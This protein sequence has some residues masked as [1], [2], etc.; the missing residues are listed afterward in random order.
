[1]TRPFARWADEP[2]PTLEPHV[3]AWLAEHLGQLTPAPAVDAAEMDVPESALAAPALAALRQAVGDA[4]VRTDRLA[5][6]RNAAGASYDDLLRLRSGTDLHIPDAVVAPADESEV[7]AVLRAASEHGVAVVPLGG[8]TSVVGGVEPIAGG[9]AAVVVLDLSRMS[10][11]VHLEADD[12]TARFL[13]GTT[14]PTADALLA[15]QGMVLGHVPQSYA[16]ASIGGYAATR[17]AGQSSTGFGRFDAMVVGVRMATPRGVLVAGTGTANAAGPDLKQVVVGSEGA[18]GVIT[19]VAVRV[20]RA[21]EVR[22][23]EGWVLPGFGAG[24]DVL[25]SL[26]QDGPRADSAPDVCRL[27]DPQETQVQLA[28]RG[29]GAQSAAL[30]AYLRLRKRS[31]GCLAIVGWEGRQAAVR[32]RRREAVAALRAS[33]GVSLGTAAGE[34]W[35]RNRFDAPSQRDSLIAA[36]VLVETLETATTWSRVPALRE[37]IR[38]ALGRSLGEFGTPPVVMTHLSHL[39]PTGASLYVTVLARQVEGD[40]AAAREQ[41]H[42]AKAAA[43]EAILA[44]GGTLTHHHAVGRDHRPWLGREVGDLG[45]E[46]LGAVKSV[47][48]PEGVLNPGVLVG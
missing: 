11:L 25:R 5:R 28:L 39:Y 23:Y 38:A 3:R 31:D 17:S 14:G 42:A 19:E 20:R 44:A 2:L 7:L 35:R 8:G 40:T 48:D 18:L 6:L 1:V 46:V 34:A 36:G 45:V 24:V 32:E 43:T 4:H 37:A 29:G 15:A 30:D 41:W 10:G 33:G 22:R 21:P 26:V 47:L 12:R 9:Q 13:P 16:R 27:S